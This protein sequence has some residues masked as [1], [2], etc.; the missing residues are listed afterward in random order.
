MVTRLFHVS[1]THSKALP[2]LKPF[3]YRVLA[4][5]QFCDNDDWDAMPLTDANAAF[6]RKYNQHL[7]FYVTPLNFTR[8][9]P[10]LSLCTD[11]RNLAFYTKSDAALLPHL[12]GLQPAHLALNPCELLHYFNQVDSHASPGG[13]TIANFGDCHASPWGLSNDFLVRHAKLRQGHSK[14]GHFDEYLSKIVENFRLSRRNCGVSN[15]RTGTSR[16]AS[17]PLSI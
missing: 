10:I 16:H 12:E 13:L 4:Y 9:F 15:C 8:I 6:I 7:L 14:K 11:V 17:P 3:L 2:R 5:D 1:A